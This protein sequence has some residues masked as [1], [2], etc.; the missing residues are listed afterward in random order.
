MKN[1][2][3]IARLLQQRKIIA[4]PTE[5]IYGLSGIIDPDV[6][7]K[8]MA[9]K[10]RDIGK[11]FIIVSRAIQHLLSFVNT[12]QLTRSQIQKI[13][14]PCDKP[15]TWI[16]PAQEKIL[17]L[18]GGSANIAIRLTTHP[19]LA[20]ITTQLDQAII[21]TS[22]NISGQP[23]ATTAQEVSDYFKAQLPYIYPQQQQNQIRPS[24]IIDLV[25]GV[26]LRA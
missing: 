13:S 3:T 24:Q 14:T 15:T 10:E 5:S 18:T 6:V 8:L 17:W 26:V 1:I 9:I 21:S 11:G 25:S 12:K 23:P 16:V 20:T 4:L 7:A 19:L 2:N 22:A